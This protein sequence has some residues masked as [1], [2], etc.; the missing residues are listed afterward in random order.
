MNVVY[1]SLLFLVI[2]NFSVI[3]YGTNIKM[4]T[5]EII[6]DISSIF[7]NY[8]APREWK[9]KQFAWDLDKKLSDLESACRSVNDLQSFHSNLKNF[10]Q[11]SRDYHTSILFANNG[12]S[13]LPI[14]IKYIEGKFYVSYVAKSYASCILQPG[15]Q[16][17][18][19]GDKDVE[20]IALDLIGNIE[21]PSLTDWALASKKLTVR[22]GVFGDYLEEGSVII[23]AKRKNELITAQLVWNYD[24]NQVSF[25]T[26]SLNS[27]FKYDQAIESRIPKKTKKLLQAMTTN[28]S[29]LSYKLKLFDFLQQD[30]TQQANNPMS[31][32]ERESYLPKLG[33]IIVWQAEEKNPWDAY[34]YLNEDKKLIG[35]IRIPNYSPD[36]KLG[37][38]NFFVEKFGETLN[39][40]NEITD[41]LVID[42]LNNPGGN[43]LYLYALASII[44][45]EPLKT[46]HHRFS[47][48]SKD[49]WD[50]HNSLKQLDL[51]IKIFDLLGVKELGSMYGYPADIQFF[52]HMK[53]YFQFIIK[54]WQEGKTLTDPY[55]LYGVDY[56]RPHPNYSYSKPILL[57]INELDFSGGDFFPEIAQQNK[58]VTLMGANTA[59]AGGYVLSKIERN[60]AGIIGYSYTSSLAFKDNGYPLENLGIAPHIEY[61]VSPLDLKTGFVPFKNEINNN[62][63]NI[64]NAS[65]LP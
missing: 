61:M 56:I 5:E 57:L 29:G 62:I 18:K 50:A 43:I 16:I 42:Q 28:L 47:I 54:Q 52:F 19:I 6:Q 60:R 44:T 13:S 27:S 25:E 2:F 34:V 17:I 46:P 51:L 9:S 23:Q 11:S 14:S 31:L 35:F 38:A 58:K 48:D 21:N 41:M 40:M 37:D 22:L 63:K 20:T 49:V 4:E 15:D 32:G 3:S 45:K 33:D 26:G 7:R 12:M 8:Y 10:F 30:S 36:E 64:L 39:K 55:F 59:G 24:E 53:S 1:K 65:N